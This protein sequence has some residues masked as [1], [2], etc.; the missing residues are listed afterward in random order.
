[1]PPYH[2]CALSG[3]AKIF[4][5][6]QAPKGDPKSTS[7]SLLFVMPLT[8]EIGPETQHLLER[9]YRQSHHHRVRQRAHCLA[10]RD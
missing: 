9:L 8:R 2:A 3:C 6:F 10:L 1:M 5:V 4:T 7:Y